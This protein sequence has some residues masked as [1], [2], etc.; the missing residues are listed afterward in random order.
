M[1]KMQFLN[2]ESQLGR[3]GDDFD[4]TGRSRLND[5]Q[6]GGVE[7]PLGEQQGQQGDV[8]AQTAQQRLRGAQG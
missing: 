3:S 6:V 4:Q 2:R 5:L 7:S 8:S 1:A